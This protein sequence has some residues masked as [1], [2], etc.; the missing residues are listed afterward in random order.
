MRLNRC[1]TVKLNRLF[2]FILF[3]LSNYF[4]FAGE[5]VLL[6]EPPTNFSVKAEVVA[7][8]PFID[9]EVL[10]LQRLPTHPQAN[11]WCPPGGKIHF[12]ETAKNAAIR[13]LFEETG[14]KSDQEFLIDL[15]RYYVRYPNGDFIFYLYKINISKIDQ[16]NIRISKTEHQNFCICSVDNISNFPL[17]PGLDE[18]FEIAMN[19]QFNF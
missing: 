14:I 19:K 1:P 15:G 11:L 9:N 6:N 3:L 5:R 7:V 18:C 12:G 13:E 8:L 4:C 10:L 2:Y 16:S 17:T